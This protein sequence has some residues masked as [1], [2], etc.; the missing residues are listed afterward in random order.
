MWSR[1]GSVRSCELDVDAMFHC[2]GDVFE[3]F[4]Q[5]DE[6]QRVIEV[7]VPVAFC[8][9]MS[10][11]RAYEIWFAYLRLEVRQRCEPK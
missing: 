1:S 3:P 10:W 9:K 11:S 2:F 4:G 6:V 5:C 7:L 8:Y